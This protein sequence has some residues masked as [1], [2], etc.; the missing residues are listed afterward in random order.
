MRM[1]GPEREWIVR[2]HID[3]RGERVSARML[4]PEGGWIVRSHIGWRGEQSIFYKSVKTSPQ[5]SQY[6]NLDISQIYYQWRQNLKKLF[7]ICRTER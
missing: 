2:S 4:G 7:L 5:P 1:L 3:W 6:N